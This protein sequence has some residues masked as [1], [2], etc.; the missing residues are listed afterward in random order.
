MGVSLLI[1]RLNWGNPGHK[2]YFRWRKIGLIIV[3][4]GTV[5]GFAAAYKIR[6]DVFDVWASRLYSDR[7]NTS[8]GDDVNLIS[9]VAEAKGIWEEVSETP[10]KIFFGKGFG[11]TYHWSDS[12]M[13]DVRSVSEEIVT[14]FFAPTW[15]AAH[16]PLPMHYSSA[17]FR[18]CFGRSGFLQPRYGMDGSVCAGFAQ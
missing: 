3:C 4:C 1:T 5:I 11:N 8:S 13:A 6:P 17:V 12:Y 14:T 15:N 7:V 16:S 2:I 9:R 18:P 10:L